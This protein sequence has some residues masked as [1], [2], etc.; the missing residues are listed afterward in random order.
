VR[1][2]EDPLRA[3]SDEAVEQV[4]GERTVDLSRGRRRPQGSVL[5]RV[6]DVDVEAVLMRGVP[7][8]AELRPE[9]AAVWTAEV[10]DQDVRRG[11]VREAVP[12]DDVEDDPDE[13]IAP[14]PA[15][16]AIRAS[17]QDGVP[18]GEEPSARG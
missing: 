18:R 12:G 4:L 6:V 15:P 9:T 2:D 11:R 7:E 16:R 17:L 13:A 8:A 5:T 3:G 10:A 14:P 1:A